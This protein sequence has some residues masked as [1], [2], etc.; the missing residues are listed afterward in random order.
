[1][2]VAQWYDCQVLLLAGGGGT[3]GAQPQPI[4]TTNYSPC[5]MKAMLAQGL[6]SGAEA[7]AKAAGCSQQ[8][9]ASSG[10]GASYSAADRRLDEQ[11]LQMANSALALQG[12]FESSAERAMYEMSGGGYMV[13]VDTVGRAQSI[14]YLRQI[15]RE[16]ER[17]LRTGRWDIGGGGMA[18]SGSATTDADASAQEIHPAEI[19]FDAE[20][21]SY[22]M[23]HTSIP[24]VAFYEATKDGVT[25]SYYVNTLTGER[26]SLDQLRGAEGLYGSAQLSNS[27]PR[28][29]E[30]AFDGNVQ[31]RHDPFQPP[32]A[33]QW[34]AD[35]P[36]LG[37]N[38]PASGAQDR[39]QP[40]SLADGN[41][42][43]P[44]AEKSLGADVVGERQFMQDLLRENGPL[45]DM[46]Y[47]ALGEG[48]AQLLNG[49]WERLGNGRDVVRGTNGSDGAQVFSGGAMSERVR[50]AV[51]IGM[52]L[53]EGDYRPL[54]DR[55][56]DRAIPNSAIAAHVQEN[57]QTLGNH[58]D[59]MDRL[60]GSLSNAIDDPG[61]ADALARVDADIT[62]VGRL[63]HDFV[64]SRLRGQVESVQRMGR[65]TVTWFAEHFPRE[66][67]NLRRLFQ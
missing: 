15:K 31:P 36:F 45:A 58:A 2:E 24:N 44:G 25:E 37:S 59:R 28:P 16:L 51:E 43:W 29:G 42:A 53:Q 61:D 13:S 48:A 34:N 23:F 7:T 1:M 49:A 12:V 54:A 47:G 3:C 14:E 21:G 32:A 8:A 50:D 35:A 19:G 64:P 30:M 18:G 60:T 63:D 22:R 6:T 17:R 62:N 65:A 56:I 26:M 39:Q 27:A 33:K 41:G 46:Y 66:S 20:H 9:A 57:S 40:P 11:F 67:R 52:G 5:C 55:A 38:S 10:K 4:P